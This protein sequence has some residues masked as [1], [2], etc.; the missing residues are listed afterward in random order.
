MNSEILQDL[1][2]KI[3]KY[4]LEFLETDFKRQQAPKRRIVLQ[5]DN[6][7]KCGMRIA[8]Y[9][10]LQKAIWNLLEKPISDEL[11]LTFKPKT[12]LRQLSNSLKLVLR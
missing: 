8:P 11:N 4:F 7:F 2:I 3:S 1:S 9:A 10:E 12:Y 6:G 5:Q